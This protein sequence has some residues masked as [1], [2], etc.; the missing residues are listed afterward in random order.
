[1]SVH[2]FEISDPIPDDLQ[3]IKS[4]T[5]NHSSCSKLLFSQAT[6]RQLSIKKIKLVVAKAK[7]DFQNEKSEAI[8][9]RANKRKRNAES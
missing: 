5:M 7:L 6:S 9:K 4:H 3:Y 2:K 1:M 8:N